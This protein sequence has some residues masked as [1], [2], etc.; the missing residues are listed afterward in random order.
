LLLPGFFEMRKPFNQM[1]AAPER[2]I[3][4]VKRGLVRSGPFSIGT[5][6]YRKVPNAIMNF[7]Q[8]Q[9]TNDAANETG[10]AKKAEPERQRESARFSHGEGELMGFSQGF[11]RRSISWP[12]SCS[13]DGP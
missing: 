5:H 7:T 2:P 12:D 13:Y 4:P 11:P 1:R 3:G 10:S 6:G 8:R 9:V